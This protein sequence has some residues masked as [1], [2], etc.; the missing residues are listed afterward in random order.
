MERTTYGKTGLSNALEHGH[1]HAIEAYH[2]LLKKLLSE[3]T[4][5]PQ[6]RRMMPHLVD[7]KN[8]DGAS[9]LTH[10]G[11]NGHYAA[12]NAFFAILDDPAIAPYIGRGSIPLVRRQ[13]EA[14]CRRRPIR[15][16]RP[17]RQLN[18]LH[19]S[20]ARQSGAAPSQ[21]L[22]A[23]TLTRDRGT[24]GYQPGHTGSPAG[25]HPPGQPLRPRTAKRPLFLPDRVTMTIDSTSSAPSFS[26]AFTA[27]LCPGGRCRPCRRGDGYDRHT[28]V[29]AIRPNRTAPMPISAEANIS[30]GTRNRCARTCPFLSNSAGGIA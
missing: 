28:R 8:R 14:Q 13:V 17:D 7:M 12:I 30:S 23:W 24:L 21:R 6:I 4:V 25:R 3:P 27:A 9:G 29:G 18:G 19:Q 2:D 22:G 20:P 16:A 15:P 5:A 26:V 11:N 1:A 10:A